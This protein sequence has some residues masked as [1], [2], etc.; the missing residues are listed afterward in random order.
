MGLDPPITSIKLRKNMSKKRITGPDLKGQG[1]GRVSRIT[2]IKLRKNMSKKRITGPLLPV[3]GFE[4]ISH[5]TVQLIVSYRTPVLGLLKLYL[6]SN[7][8]L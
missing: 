6:K 3:V 5:L 2:S 1:L 4:G 7:I 8:K